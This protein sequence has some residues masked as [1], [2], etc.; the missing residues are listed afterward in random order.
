MIDAWV[1]IGVDVTDRK[2]VEG[3][4]HALAKKLEE[5]ASNLSDSYLVAL[6]G[7][8]AKDQQRKDTFRGLL[9]ESII[10]Y[11]EII[12]ALDEMA[13][14]MKD[15]W[16]IKPDVD[17]PIQF[18]GLAKTEASWKVAGLSD[19]TIFNSSGEAQ[20][21]TRTTALFNG[22]SLNGWHTDG[23]QWQVRDG[24]LIG[25]KLVPNEA[26]SFLVS[27]KSYKN[28][29]LYAEFKLLEGNSGIQIRS[30]EKSTG[31]VVGPQ[32]DITFQQEYRWLGCLTGERIQP[33]IIAQ[34]TQATKDRLRQ[35]VDPNGWNS[36]K[37]SVKERQAIIL[38]NNLKTIQSSLP[39][40]YESGV[41]A[42]QLHG[43]GRT[44]IEFRKIE[45]EEH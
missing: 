3:K 38:I 45:I 24:V 10:R 28:F 20:A 4:F 41:I 43:G 6:E 23:N 27:D 22:L 35:A 14:L 37:V 9:Q 30:L 13:T 34:T 25:E 2:S 1:R 40:G 5:S 32:A 33:D 12:L 8:M 7:D 11:A 31:M 19:P 16:Q 15:D 21:A 44:R 36:I 18:V 29:D 26:G 39:A 42:L 17:K